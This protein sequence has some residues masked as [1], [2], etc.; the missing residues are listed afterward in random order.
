M[1]HIKADTKFKPHGDEALSDRPVAVKL[2]RDID[3]AVRALPDMSNWLRRVITEAAQ[4]ELIQQ[5][6]QIFKY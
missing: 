2:P 6:H 4:R 1:N 5:D 3:L